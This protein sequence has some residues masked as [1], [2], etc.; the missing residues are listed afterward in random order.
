MKIVD[1]AQFRLWPRLAQRHGARQ[2]RQHLGKAKPAVESVSRL[3][4]IA[5]RV[6]GLPHG[7]VAAADGALDVAQHHVHPARAL[8][9]GGGATT[10]GLQHGMRMI[11]FD[12]A[13][14]TA[15]AVAED[16]GI[17]RQTPD[18]GTEEIKRYPTD[19]RGV[20]VVRDSA[21]GLLIPSVPLS[22]PASMRRYFEKS[23]P[24]DMRRAVIGVM[25]Y[26]GI[27]HTGVDCCDIAKGGKVRA[28]MWPDGKLDIGE[29][30]F[31]NSFGMIAATLYHE[32][33]VHWDLQLSKP[34]VVLGDTQAWYM[35]EVQ[36]YDLEIRNSSRFNL[37]PAEVKSLKE[38]RAYDLNG[39]NSWNRSSVE[40]GVYKP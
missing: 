12:H 2:S 19:G 37:S 7:V 24:E 14:E 17:Q 22:T 8:D 9:F 36:A 20:V 11:Q 33:G 32:V 40:S 18:K 38:N 15:Q 13:P 30:L 27:D 3:S 26:F 5:P 21:G 4:Q 39:L 1:G 10:G 31:S 25:D 29:K 23:G 34:D 6:L 28:E 35:R 16:F